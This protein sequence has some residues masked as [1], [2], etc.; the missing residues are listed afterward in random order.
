MQEVRR[1]LQIFLALF[2]LVTG[3][4]T[5]G[6]MVLE[7]LSFA[8]AFYYN[9]VT[10]STVG[11]GDIHPTS[12]AGRMFAILLI[13]MGGA[14]FLGVIANAT[15]MLILKRESQNR[16]RKIN[17][18]LG[19]FFSEVGY[20]LLSVFS[21]NDHVISS[22]RENLLV[23][24]NWTESNFTTALKI[25]KGYEAKIDGSGVDLEKLSAFLKSK[26]GF[27][28]G[29][30]EN[31]M[32]I[33]HE[34]FSEALLSVFHLLDELSSRNDLKDLPDSDIKHLA[35]DI[36]RV[37]KK[38]IVQW[39]VYMKHLKREYPYLFSLAI[40]VNP[41]DKNASPVVIN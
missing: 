23:A 30:L 36:S 40:R 8:D 10:M 7:D 34:D 39:I 24:A 1:R 20:K 4:G 22:I 16:T 32:L 29:L 19:I 14:T 35:G 11:Y 12:Q 13:V 38:L 3:I 17:M 28:L 18:V 31:P 9:I 2:F 37:Y 6:F 15:E 33:E 5:T 26:R 21:S 41:F 27:L 25:I